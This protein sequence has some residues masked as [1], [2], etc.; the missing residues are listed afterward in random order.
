MKSYIII[1][2]STFGKY[3]TQYLYE[4]GFEVI[5][6]DSEEERVEEVKPYLLEGI[7][8]NAKEKDTLKKIGV[9]DV[10]G[11]IVSLGQK[12][13]DSLL[14]ILHLKELKVQNIYVKVLT[15]D[16]AK[17]INMI[18]ASDIVFPERDSAYRLAQRIDNPNIL[19][20]IPLTE[21]YSII[22]WAPTESFIGKTIGEIDLRKQ[23]GVQ[24]VSIEETRPERVKLIPR[25]THVI[26]ASDTLVIIGENE[27]LEK[28][29]KLEE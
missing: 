4:K 7:V 26:K 2:L 24:V 1:G 12:V 19:D 23:Y 13:D 15:D 29:K 17:I 5:A 27:N 9:Q 18:E 28:L 6:I 21:E 14:V 11:V 3:L 16:H 10:D 20:Y 22:D 8:G 25:S